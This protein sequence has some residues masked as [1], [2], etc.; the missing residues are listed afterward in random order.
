MITCKLGDKEYF[1]DFVSLRTLREMKPALE[2]YGQINAAI[3]A[4]AKGEAQPE[5]QLSYEETMDRMVLWFCGLFGNQFTPDAVYSLY[6]VDRFMHDV[7]LAI[8]A[9]Q[10][11]QTEA[12]SGFPTKA[13]AAKKP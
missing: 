1:I 2:A 13:A 4:A 11:G 3:S 7:M 12:L 5:N 8:M 10:Q 9:V 6:P